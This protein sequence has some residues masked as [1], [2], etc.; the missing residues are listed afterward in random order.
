MSVSA[1][2]TTLVLEEQLGAID[3]WCRRHSWAVHL[4]P[5]DMQLRFGA[6]HPSGALLEVTA[7]VDGYPALPPAWRFVNPGTDE[8]ST[9]FPSPGQL[10]G[11]GGSILHGSHVICAP[12]NRCAYQAYDPRGPHPEWSVTGWQEVI[13]YTR[14][15]TIADMLDQIRI[16]LRLSPGFL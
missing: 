5:D 3:A 15:L 12:W 1:S 8:E 6:Y 16:H 9:R 14:A 7:G 11:T 10:P 2:L 13:G 4:R